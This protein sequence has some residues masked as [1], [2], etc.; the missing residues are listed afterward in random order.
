MEI[1]ICSMCIT[2]KHINKFLK[3]NIPNVKH[4]IV[5]DV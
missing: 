4:V 2:E 3:K 5:K 1:K